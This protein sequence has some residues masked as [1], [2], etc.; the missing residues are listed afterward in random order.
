M[1]FIKDL[2][3]VQ[4]CGMSSA[5]EENLKPNLIDTWILTWYF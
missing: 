3:C 4:H 1:P 5:A 2:V